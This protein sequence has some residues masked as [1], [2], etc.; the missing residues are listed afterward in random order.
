MRLDV[1]DF[2]S[3]QF[4]QEV[5]RRRNARELHDNVVQ[6]LIALVTDLEYFRIRADNGVGM[7]TSSLV[8]THIAQSGYQQGLLGLHE[9]AM[10]LGGR[11]SIES[12][13]GIGTCLKVDMP[14][15]Q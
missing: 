15:P 9:R 10:L 7:K 4:A 14:L 3:V 2:P 5:E 12:T 6:S 13:P 1:V 8:G 11:I